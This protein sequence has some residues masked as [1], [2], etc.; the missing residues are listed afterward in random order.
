MQLCS[1]Q[2]SGWTN[3]EVTWA[4][5]ALTSISLWRLVTVVLLNSTSDIIQT[6]TNRAILTDCHRN[7]NTDTNTNTNRNIETSMSKYDTVQWYNATLSKLAKLHESRGNMILNVA[8]FTAMFCPPNS[9]TEQHLCFCGKS[10]HIHR[11]THV[12]LNTKPLDLGRGFEIFQ[13]GVGTRCRPLLR[14]DDDETRHF[15]VSTISCYAKT[16]AHHLLS[17]WC[18]HQLCR[19]RCK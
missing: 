2:L 5:L 9:G 12:I 17:S 16:S 19:L 6:G 15:C 4:Q 1:V 3:F 14:G 7:T 11:P 10:N 18:Q 8:H 13:S